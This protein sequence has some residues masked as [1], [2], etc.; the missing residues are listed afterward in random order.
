MMNMATWSHQIP[1]VSSFNMQPGLSHTILATHPCGLVIRDFEWITKEATLGEVP[2]V[3][4]RAVTYGLPTY[5][6]ISLQTYPAL[7]HIY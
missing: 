4:P 6:R 7:N 1:W 5:T 2:E 3:P